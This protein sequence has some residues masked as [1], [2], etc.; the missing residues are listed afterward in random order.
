MAYNQVV[1]VTLVFGGVPGGVLG[2]S[3]PA[4]PGNA[5]TFQ[6]IG[7]WGQTAQALVYEEMWRQFFRYPGVDNGRLGNYLNFNLVNGPTPTPYNQTF[8]A[9]TFTNGSPN[10]TG[11]SSTLGLS[12]GML[13]FCS[14]AG[15]VGIAYVINPAL[16]ATSLVLNQNFAGTTGSYTLTL[17]PCPPSVA[18]DI[19]STP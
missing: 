19:I 6:A 13:A 16:S 15:L 7:P 11:L 5:A 9:V 3:D 17:V 10:V 18:N 1:A 2:S 14:V 4:G 12:A 8:A